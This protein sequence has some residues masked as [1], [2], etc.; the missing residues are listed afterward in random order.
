MLKWARRAGAALAVAAVVLVS[1]SATD[2][3]P[4]AADCQARAGGTLRLALMSGGLRRTALLHVPRAASAGRNLP[5]VLAFH[6]AGGTGAWMEDYSGLT[7]LSDQR[8]FMVAYPD[9]Y[10]PRRVWNL[11]G[12]PGAVP[13]DV[14]FTSDLIAAIDR[15]ACLEP[16]Q[17]FAT[18]VSNGGG[19]TA[20]LGCD[21]SGVLRAIAPV[22]GGYSTLPSCRPTR[23]VSVLEIHGVRDPVVP[24]RG[25]GTARA[26]DVI[27]YVRAWAKRD[28]CPRR[29]TRWPVAREVMRLQWAPCAQGA[30][31]AH[32]RLADR[33]HEWPAIASR[34]V[35][36][37]FA[38][39]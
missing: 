27:R 21:L 17:V 24:Y 26:G 8:G 10:G 14:A 33:G 6:G 19:M 32:L 35:W 29:A 25:R 39:R 2:T 20:R 22:A 18:G 11:A 7:K 15:R 5:L 34:Q 3:H 30:A 36:S 12:P 38:G 28:R 16:A 13:D 23:P 37:F 1:A 31:V 9:A 4:A